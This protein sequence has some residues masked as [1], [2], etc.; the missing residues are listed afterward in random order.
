MNKINGTIQDQIASNTPNHYE[1]ENHNIECNQPI[2]LSN[3]KQQFS[4]L[5]ITV[6]ITMIKQT[7]FSQNLKLKR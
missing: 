2:S 6:T 7:L 5:I 1:K 3:D 4:V